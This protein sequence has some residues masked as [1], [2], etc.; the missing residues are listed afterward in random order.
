MVAVEAIDPGEPEAVIDARIGEAGIQRVVAI[1]V[2]FAGEVDHPATSGLVALIV[3][4]LTKHLR[5]D[6]AGGR[7]RGEADRR[8]QLPSWL[9]FDLN[10][11]VEQ[12]LLLLVALLDDLDFLEEAEAIDVGL[13][14]GQPRPAIELTIG[15]VKLATDDVV[16][17]FGVTDDD[18]L[19]EINLFALGDLIIERHQALVAVKGRL[20]IDIGIGIAK[21]T[22]LVRQRLDVFG[23]ARVAKQLADLQLHRVDQLRLGKEQITANIQ[24]ANAVLQALLDLKG[25]THIVAV[26]IKKLEGLSD[27]DLGKTLI[28]VDVGDVFQVALNEVFLIQRGRAKGTAAG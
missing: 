14:A 18:H 17:G 9:F 23:K 10:V 27:L 11:E 2:P 3:P 4:P 13:G 21:V 19:T 28:A 12:V 22:V 8:L 7:V 15:D 1:T 16:A 24:R 6:R 25:Q 20:R 26:D 5:A